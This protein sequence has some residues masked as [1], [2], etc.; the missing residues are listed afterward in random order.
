[1]DRAEIA[2]AGGDEAHFGFFDSPVHAGGARPDFERLSGGEL[3]AKT[4]PGFGTDVGHGLDEM[5]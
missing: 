2:F 3:V 1:M 4:V 5:H